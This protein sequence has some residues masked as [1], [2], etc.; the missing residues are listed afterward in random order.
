MVGTVLAIKLS[1]IV[2][3]RVTIGSDSAQES[4]IGLYLCREKPKESIKTVDLFVYN[5]KMMT[6]D[7]V[8]PSFGLL[9]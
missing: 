6:F 9:A 5:P 2:A 4:D 7:M 8:K 3:F 1:K